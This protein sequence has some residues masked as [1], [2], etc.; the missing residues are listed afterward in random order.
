MSNEQKVESINKLIAE[1]DWNAVG[2]TAAAYEEEESDSESEHDVTPEPTSK[3]LLDFFSGGWKKSESDGAQPNANTSDSEVLSASGLMKDV[4][5]NKETERDEKRDVGEVVVPG[6]SVLSDGS[7]SSDS[8]QSSGS[9]GDEDLEL[10][11]RVKK[12]PTDDVDESMEEGDF[13]E[14]KEHADALMETMNSSKELDDDSAYDPSDSDYDTDESR[15]KQSVKSNSTT[16]N[17]ER[18]ASLEKLIESDDWQGIVT[19]AVVNEDGTST[20]GSALLKETGKS[21]TTISSDR[22]SLKKEEQDH[23]ETSSK[24]DWFSIADESEGIQSS[25]KE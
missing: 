25:G 15:G 6:A 14:L 11:A 17:D 24:E 16:I 20:I 21:A 12:N 22:S 9:H 19:P 4:E 2:S 3:S 13:K 7:K 18:I 23:V 5:G 1:G 8:S 10:I